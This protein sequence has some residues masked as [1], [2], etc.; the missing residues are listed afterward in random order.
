MKHWSVD[1]KKLAEYPE[2]YAR[3]K[4]E[5][6]VNAGLRDGKVKRQDLQ[7][8]WDTLELDPHKRKFLSLAFEE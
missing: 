5:Q 1:M 4:I 2:Q 8:Y 7:K 6:A 3:W